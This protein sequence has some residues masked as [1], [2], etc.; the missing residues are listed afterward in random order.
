MSLLE[1]CK[2]STA[3]H[4]HI[5]IPVPRQ[6]GDSL[7]MSRFQHRSQENLKRREFNTRISG[8]AVD[9]GKP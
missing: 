4:Q 9:A 3:F 6:F 5:A 1:L 7:E 2:K 8:I